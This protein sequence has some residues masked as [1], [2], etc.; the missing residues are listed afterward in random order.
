MDR[1]EDA[2]DDV[3]SCKQKGKVARLG[4]AG[5]VR[6]AVAG[7]EEQQQ[8]QSIMIVA[9]KRAQRAA[10]DRFTM[11]PPAPAAAAPAPALPRPAVPVGC[12]APPAGVLLLVYKAG[13]L[14][15]QLPVTQVMTV[16]G[17]LPQND[18]VLDHAS[19]SRQHAALCFQTQ[20]PQQGLQAILMDL[21]SAHGTFVDGARLVKQ[22]HHP[23]QPGDS[24][25]F[26]ASTRA[27]KLHLPALQQEAAV[28]KRGRVMFAD[29][30][31]D[32][33]AQ[34]GSGSSSQVFK[35]KR[36]LEEVFTS[37]AGVDSNQMAVGTG[38]TLSWWAGQRRPGLSGL[39]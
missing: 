27:Y 16:F 23:L 28:K 3:Q 22:Q 34:E 9:S 18:V 8:Q 21:G 37:V 26:G 24:I 19:I 2:D 14:L 20:E 5:F 6:A 7:E 11:P 25:Q 35:Q 17:R 1:W 36:K 31:E 38:A 12:V 32:E 13:E 10:A 39:R 4:I 33:G 15:Q 30:V 29:S